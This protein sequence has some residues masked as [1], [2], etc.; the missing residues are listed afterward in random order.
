MQSL[1]DGT[2]EINDSVLIL[3]NAIFTP[4]GRDKDI[5][6]GI[7]PQ[8]LT[9][10]RNGVRLSIE[11]SPKLLRTEANFA[12]ELTKANMEKIYE[13]S[14][15]GWDDDDKMQ[16]LTEQGARFLLIRDFSI[17][18][19]SNKSLVAFV[20]F[21]FTVQGEV[22]DQMIGD[23]CLY[24]WDLQ[25]DHLHQRNGLGRHLLT[26]LELIARRERMSYV[27]IPI[28]NSDEHSLSW[29]STIRGFKPDAEL[30]SLVSF[31][32]KIEGFNVL[33][34]NLCVG[35]R[36]SRG[37][38][39][40]PVSNDT[41]PLKSIEGKNARQSP[42]SIADVAGVESDIAGMVL[43]DDVV[44]NEMEEDADLTGLTEQDVIEG[45]KE[46]FREK[47]GRD[48]TD[49]EVQQWL[50]AINKSEESAGT[51]SVLG[52]ETNRQR[53]SV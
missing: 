7:A 47:N 53:V 31:D 8:F 2:R 43:K 22:M 17:P 16:E 32:S 3:R 36:R 45:L 30:T 35:P 27:S 6:E 14:G 25:I 10:T 11:F 52:M 34:K 5:T 1:S 18:T 51:A 26:L 9:Y 15:Y 28:P 20:H 37:Q 50:E 29:I 40:T 49:V 33:T 4:A 46:L 21:R 19:S 23:P 44:D 12:F 39:G 13:S 38:P 42:V 41:S 24:I 48:V